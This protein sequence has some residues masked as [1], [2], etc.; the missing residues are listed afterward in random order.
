M[1]EQKREWLPAAWADEII[2]AVQEDVNAFIH[3]VGGEFWLGP[4]G[5]EWAEAT[6]FHKRRLED[7]CIVNFYALETYEDITIYVEKNGFSTVPSIIDRANQFRLAEGEAEYGCRSID[8]VVE[9]GFDG[10][11]LEPGSYE[12]E[13]WWW[14]DEEFSYRFIIENGNGRFEPFDGRL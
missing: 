14:S 3:A 9:N 8:D 1:T 7:G 13:C 11:R 4:A 10:K 12:V 5:D 2:P 6:D